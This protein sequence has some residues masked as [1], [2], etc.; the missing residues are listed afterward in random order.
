M[1]RFRG[2]LSRQH[3]DDKRVGR[4]RRRLRDA[5]A[6]ARAS[7]R[8]ADVVCRHISGTTDEIQQ[9]LERLILARARAGPGPVGT[10]DIRHD[11]MLST[12]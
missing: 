1:S 7:R 12:E 3:D 5:E 10:G 6:E 9:R 2:W 4:A 11:L 8:E